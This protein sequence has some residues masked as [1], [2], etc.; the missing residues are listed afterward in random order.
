MEQVSKVGRTNLQHLMMLFLFVGFVGV[1]FAVKVQTDKLN[2]IS[3]SNALV[4]LKMMSVVIEQQK[5]ID[6]YEKIIVGCLNGD[7]AIVDA[8]D[9]PC[10]FGE[11]IDGREKF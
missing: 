5:K 6:T 1:L 7:G 11:Y 10:R 4:A 2:H 3:K 8:V 9:R